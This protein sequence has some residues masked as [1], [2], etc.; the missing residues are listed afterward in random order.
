VSATPAGY[1]R[2]LKECGIGEGSLPEAGGIDDEADAPRIQVS[3]LGI[4]G[5]PTALLAASF[6]GAVVTSAQGN[7]AETEMLYCL[8]A[9]IG[10]VYPDIVAMTFVFPVS[11]F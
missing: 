9:D 1:R 5:T 3:V 8:L 4:D 10:E 7:D 2:L 11:S 6:I